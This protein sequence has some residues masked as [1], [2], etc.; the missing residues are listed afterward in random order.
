MTL[1]LADLHGDTIATTAVNPEA[2]EL[3]DTQ[4]F[5]E[6]GNPLQSGFLIGGKAEYGW[7]GARVAELS[8]LQA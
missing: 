2:T 4:R 5:D 8:C 1:Q 7:L 6:Y 3:L